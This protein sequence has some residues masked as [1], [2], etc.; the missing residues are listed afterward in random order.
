MRKEVRTDLAAMLRGAILALQEGNSS[1]L[2][3]LSNHSI[4]NASIYGD[5]DSLSAAVLLYTISKLLARGSAVAN[6]KTFASTIVQGLGRVA[7]AVKAD[8]E[9]A[10][11][12]CMRSLFAEIEKFDSKLK[13][14]ITEVITQ[15]QIKKGSKLYEHGF[16]LAHAAALLGITQ[17]ELQSYIGHTTIADMEEGTDIRSRI[18]FARTLF[19]HD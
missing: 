17:W 3:E 11:H 18:L 14:Y 16:S 6:G 4:H 15:A 10:V 12:Q 19:A 8:D 13:L 1:A 5:E 9:E 2:A 7:A